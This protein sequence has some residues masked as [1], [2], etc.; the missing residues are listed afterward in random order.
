MTNYEKLL[1]EQMKDPEFVKAYRKARW[2]RVLT[3]F[4]ENLKD[5]ISRGEPKEDLLSTIDSM[6]KELSSL[7]T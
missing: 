4:L 7:Q 5:K 6:Q 2:E 3:E 1:Q